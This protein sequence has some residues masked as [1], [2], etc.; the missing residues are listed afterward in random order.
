MKE[1]SSDCNSCAVYKCRKGEKDNLPTFCPMNDEAIY[2]EASLLLEKHREFFVKCSIVEKKGYGDWPR[3]R[4]TIEFIKDMNYKKIGLAFCSG[5]Q[6]EAKM[7]SEIFQD[8]GIDL[9]SVMCKTGGI[10]K[11]ISGIDEEFKLRPGQFEPH[12]NPI[13]QALVLN[14]EETEFNLILGL[15]V[16]HDSLFMKHSEAL[17][18]TLVVKDRVTGH[19][20]VVALYLKD[21]YMKS[22]LGL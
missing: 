8:H 6:R 10:D 4:E 11:S 15:C 12:C 21:S 1:Y 22:K 18:T 14:K 13:A 20:P 16:G 17:C 19:N 2:E 5:F 9:I 7:L 3:V